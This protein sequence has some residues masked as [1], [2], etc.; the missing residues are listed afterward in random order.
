ML[1]KTI[2][3]KSGL[4]VDAFLSTVENIPLHIHQTLEFVMVLEGALEVREGY[5]SDILNDGDIHI[6]NPPDLHCMTG[7]SKTNYVLTLYI[8]F[9]YLTKFY[10]GINHMSFLCDC[11]NQKGSSIDLLRH[12]LADIYFHFNQNDYKDT[13]RLDEDLG[14]LVSLLLD[15]FLL[16]RWLPDGSD[17][18]SYGCPTGFRINAFHAERIHS[19]QDYIYNH[20]AENITLGDLA[21]HEYLSTYYLSHYIKQCTGLSFQQ[22]LSAVRSEHAEKLLISTNKTVSEIA[23]DVGFAST[24]YLIS[25]FKKWYGC[26]P[27]R[28]REITASMHSHLPHKYYSCDRM[29]AEKL[30]NSYRY[31]SSHSGKDVQKGISI[32]RLLEKETL[33]PKSEN[34][35]VQHYMNLLMLSGEI[36]TVMLKTEGERLSPAMS[37]EAISD[38]MKKIPPEMLS[39]YEAFLTE[40]M[41]IL[42]ILPQKE[43]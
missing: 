11:E 3:F 27:S 6:F 10:P 31:E 5:Q 30:L 33:P 13:D 4:P 17:H 25:N 18:F 14:N 8:D 21:K 40:M 7:L 37:A 32:S 19:V 28:Y 26:T 9:N 41:R 16:F 1:E 38:E 24:K 29:K 35:K 42:K 39:S 36:C 12:M 22:W 15:S 34:A 43:A 20:F 23:L 2:H